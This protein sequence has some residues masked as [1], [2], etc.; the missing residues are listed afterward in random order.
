MT[1]PSNDPHRL[2]RECLSSLYPS[3]P[4]QPGHEGKWA[5]L[6]LHPSL[7][8]LDRLDALALQAARLTPEAIREALD[9]AVDAV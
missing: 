2:P 5:E 3:L 1:F 6:R 4:I 7:E 9:A 8:L